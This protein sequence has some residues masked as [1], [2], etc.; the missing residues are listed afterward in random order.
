M[1]AGFNHFFNEMLLNYFVPRPNTARNSRS[2][3]LSCYFAALSR[4]SRAFHNILSGI[5][6][7]FRPV[8]HFNTSMKTS[9]SLWGIDIEHPGMSY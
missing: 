1:F 3:F 4:N 5:L 6:T 7:N 2:I 8:F 9:E